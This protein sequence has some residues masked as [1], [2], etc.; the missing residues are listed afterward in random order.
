MKKIL[1]ILNSV[2]IFYNLH[3]SITSAKPQVLN[4]VPSQ[5]APIDVSEIR[6]GNYSSYLAYLKKHAKSP[7]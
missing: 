7:T 3:T 6:D 2:A 1:M 5:I 4:K